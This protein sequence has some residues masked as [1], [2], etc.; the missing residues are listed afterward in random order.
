MLPPGASPQ[1]YLQAAG[2]QSLTFWNVNRCLVQTPVHHWKV[3]GIKQWLRS[4]PVALA[5]VSVRQ[6]S[7]RE[8]TEPSLQPVGCPVHRARVA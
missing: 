7:E 1:E 6:E 3:D 8:R 5:E 2:E 4:G